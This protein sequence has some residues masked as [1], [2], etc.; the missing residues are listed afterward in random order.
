MIDV[1]VV[2]FEPLQA[3]FNLSGQV[4]PRRANVVRPLPEL[5]SRLCGNQYALSRQVL[6]RL[7]K[8]LLRTPLRVYVRGV[9]EINARIHADI[10]ETRRFR[11]I[12]IPPCLKKLVS[13][14]EGARPKEGKEPGTALCLTVVASAENRQTF[15]DARKVATIVAG[16]NTAAD[17]MTRAFI[18]GL[19]PG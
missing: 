13:T 3:T 7:A 5:K 4:L 12:G 2:R 1:D 6:D 9:K 17:V 16:H 19:K 14:A 15:S 8:N 11:D 10:D 18:A